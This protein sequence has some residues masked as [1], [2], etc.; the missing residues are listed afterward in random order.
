[1]S[2]ADADDIRHAVIIQSAQARVDLELRETRALY[3]ALFGDEAYHRELAESDKLDWEAR[4]EPPPDTPSALP[5]WRRHRWAL[6][7]SGK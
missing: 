7:L 3:R 2:T 1:M 5:G 6:K 4:Q